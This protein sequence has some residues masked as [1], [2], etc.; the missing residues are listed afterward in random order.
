MAPAGTPRAILA[1]ISQDVAK[2]L[3]MP[4]V[5]EKLTAFGSIP[6]PNTPEQ[7][8]A[9]IRSDTERYAK[10]LKDAGIATN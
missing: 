1:K 6:A 9:I 8:D 3:E 5:R 10:I 7:F 2:V 4:D